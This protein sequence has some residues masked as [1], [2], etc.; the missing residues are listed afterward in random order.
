[1]GQRLEVED[2]M[3]GKEAECPACGASFKIPFLRKS[4]NL[5]I[6]ES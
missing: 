1:M 3:A 6:E 4:Q 5:P 2:A